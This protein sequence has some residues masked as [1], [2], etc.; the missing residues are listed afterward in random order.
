VFQINQTVISDLVV[1]K[2]FVCDLKACKGACCV[3]GDS[4][5]PLEEAEA[6]LIE[7]HFEAIR[8][9]M[10]PEGI[11]AVEQNGFHY[12]D[13]EHDLVT[14]LINEAECAYTVFDEDGITWCAIEKAFMDG[15]L[16]FRKPA[17]CYLYPI[18]TKKIGE[19]EAVNFD[20]W[21]IC[22]P[23][24]KLGKKAG[25]PVYQFLKAPLTEKFGAEWFE[26]LNYLAKNYNQ[27]RE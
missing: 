24:L 7:Q 17:S 9:F 5:A 23:A 6:K 11:A 19:F 26:Q 1:T 25:T 4:G 10:R 13:D 12:I 16:P 20:T 27:L 21:D 2:R 18:R 3:H 22:K 14:M 8:S 15:K